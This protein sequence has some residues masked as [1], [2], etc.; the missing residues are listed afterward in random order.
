[1]PSVDRYGFITTPSEEVGGT[2][3]DI[4]V[5]GD[6]LAKSEF[7]EGHIEGL[8]SFKEGT[9]VGFDLDLCNGRPMV[10]H[11]PTKRSHS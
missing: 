1:M 7:H 5:H 2:P 6:E 9:M 8:R 3:E 4:F 11:A 10:R